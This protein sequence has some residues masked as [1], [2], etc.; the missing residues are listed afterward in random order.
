METGNTNITQL[1]SKFGLVIGLFYI[2]RFICIPL[3]AS[4]PGLSI[5]Y[6]AMFISAPFI[7]GYITINFREKFLGGTMSFSQGFR[8]LFTMIVCGTLIEAM[9]QFIY[10]R[11]I[12]HGMLGKWYLENISQ[13][14]EQ[15][16]K[17]IYLDQM[18][19]YV[20]AIYS[21]PAI[22]ITI[23]MLVNNIMWTIVIS[24]IIAAI[25]RKTNPKEKI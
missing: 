5:I 17:D 11:F 24:A 23:S 20:E 12:D 10:F 4:Y 21:I 13:F 7:Y 2:I 1:A 14:E 15:F 19:N 16:G 6:A 25:L 3:S 8:F 9:T 22:D 18:R